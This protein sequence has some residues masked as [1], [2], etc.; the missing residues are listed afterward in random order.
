MWDRLRVRKQEFGVIAQ[1]QDIQVKL[2]S[3]TH[4]M[5]AQHSPDHVTVQIYTRPQLQI[6]RRIIPLEHH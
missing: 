1:Q 5:S 4:L 3:Q 6:N 2:L